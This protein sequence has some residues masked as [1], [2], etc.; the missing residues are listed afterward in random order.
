MKQALRGVKG[1]SDTWLTSG[2][3]RI[4]RNKSGEGPFRLELL[5]ARPGSV[6]SGRERQQHSR[7]RAKTLERLRKDNQ[8]K[9]NTV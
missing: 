4:S 1:H 3:E 5:E 2:Q 6:R 9:P 8:D 7:R